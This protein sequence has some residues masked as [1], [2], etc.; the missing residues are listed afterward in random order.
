MVYKLG[1]VISKS[2][3]TWTASRILALRALRAY[4]IIFI[5]CKIVP[6]HHLQMGVFRSEKNTFDFANT[7]EV[8][9]KA[10]LEYFKVRG[11]LAF[12]A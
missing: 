8:N 10:C 5:S 7:R 12:E 1:A 2:H 9:V 4:K 11:C 3:E 6:N